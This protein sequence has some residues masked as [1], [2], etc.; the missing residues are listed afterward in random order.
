MNKTPTSKN[1]IPI[2]FEFDEK[3]IFEGTP[4]KYNDTYIDEKHSLLYC[5]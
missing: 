1:L 5:L 3:R 2:L 4:I